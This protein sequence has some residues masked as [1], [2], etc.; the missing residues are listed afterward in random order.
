MGSNR[1][2]VER[3]VA[4]FEKTTFKEKNKTAGG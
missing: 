3:K 1:R 2:K 4:I